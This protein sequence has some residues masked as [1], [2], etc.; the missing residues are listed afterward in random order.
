M[1]ELGFI[2]P[3]QL[4]DNI[5]YWHCGVTA[6]GLLDSGLNVKSGVH[7][8]LYCKMIKNC[9]TEIHHEALMRGVKC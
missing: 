7:Y 1:F 2:T 9:G 4:A 8:G 3:E 6:T 5:D